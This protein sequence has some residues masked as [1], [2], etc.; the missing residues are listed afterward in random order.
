MK[1]YLYIYLLTNIY[2]VTEIDVYLAT[3]IIV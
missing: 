2:P 3:C 1:M